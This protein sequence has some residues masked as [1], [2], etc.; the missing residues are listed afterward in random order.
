MNL[1]S[2]IINTALAD[3]LEVI[4]DRW[5]LLI[6]RDA[7]LGLKRFEQF[8]QNTG[9]S[10]ATLTR[11][12]SALVENDMLYKRV[13]SEKGRRYEYLLTEKGLSL[14]PV[15][16]LAWQWEYSWLDQSQ[17]NLPRALFH[18]ACGKPLEPAVVC[19][20]CCH[21]VLLEDVQWPAI[22]DGL[23]EQFEKIKSL[24]K[25][26]RV[27]TSER[28]GQEDLSLMNVSSLI[29]DRWTLLILIAAFFGQNRYDQFLKQLNIASN[30]L[31]TKLNVLLEAAVFERLVYQETPLRY[32]Y[33][34]T[35]K[36]KALYPLVMTMRQWAVDWTQDSGKELSEKPSGAL[37]KTAFL[38]HKKCDHKLVIEVHCSACSQKPWPR[39]V[40][41]GQAES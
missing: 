3:A 9:A 29:G 6:L 24:S 22:E 32:E 37:S 18:N 20:Y 19:Q 39:D 12:L 1:N 33:K 8:R 17:G 31:T 14:F 13:Y 25:Q 23:D 28:R 16:L 2:L 38:V 35:Q 34:L 30:I 11:R 21:T 41:I 5:A 7:F 10:R 36:G 26:R 40:K 15:S 4:G 27:R